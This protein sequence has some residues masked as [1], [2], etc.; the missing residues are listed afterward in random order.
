MLERCEITLSDLTSFVQEYASGLKEGRQQRECDPINQLMLDQ[1]RIA[2]N[3]GQSSTHI[4]SLRQT[5]YSEDLS[6]FENKKPGA[7]QQQVSGI[8]CGT[9]LNRT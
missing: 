9:L 3:Q 6:D 8:Y 1:D 5:V 7:R 4:N 2:A